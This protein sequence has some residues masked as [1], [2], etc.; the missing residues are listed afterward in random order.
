MIKKY[1]KPEQLKSDLK[2]DEITPVDPLSK[3]EIKILGRGYSKY[4][5]RVN[6]NKVNLMRM[7]LELK[8]KQLLL[9][10]HITERLTVCDILTMIKDHTLTENLNRVFNG[11][12][13]NTLLDLIFAITRLMNVIANEKEIA[14]TEKCYKLYGTKILN[15]QTQEIGLLI[16]LWKFYFI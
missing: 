7:E 15:L 8:G 9:F 1:N 10:P 13:E 16:Y 12:I 2:V 3:E 11:R 4:T 5:G 6:L 14:M